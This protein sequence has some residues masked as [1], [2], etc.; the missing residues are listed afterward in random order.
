MARCTRVLLDGGNSV[1]VAEEP[2]VVSSIRTESL[3]GD[4]R[5]KADNWMKLTRWPRGELG[6]VQLDPTIVQGAVADDR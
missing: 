1:L 6:D 5:T 4:R 3:Y 2:E